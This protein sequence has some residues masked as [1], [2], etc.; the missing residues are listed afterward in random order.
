MAGRRW[1]YNWTA[2][3]HLKRLRVYIGTPKPVHQVGGSLADT[4]GEGQYGGRELNRKI[5]LRFGCPEVFVSDHGT[6]FTNQVVVDFL[7]ERGVHHT[8]TPPYHIQATQ[9][10]CAHRTLKAMV[11][12]YLKERHT[13]WDE[14]LQELLFDMNT[15]V[16]T[17][18]EMSPAFSLYGPQP[19]GIQCRLQCIDAETPKEEQG[20][21]LKAIARYCAI[22][23]RYGARDS[24]QC[25][26]RA[27]IHLNGKSWHRSKSRRRQEEI[28]RCS[29]FLS[30]RP[31]LPR[32]NVREDVKSG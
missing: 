16:Q 31:F 7:R 27:H 10:E 12:P 28:H 32:C 26:D 5:F 3:S 24:R 30:Q 2:D 9:V 18:T 29:V 19:P 6:A 21:P 1:R 13:T 14:K 15:A 11:A 20:K 25:P 8:H 23:G 22:C 17:S 4:Q